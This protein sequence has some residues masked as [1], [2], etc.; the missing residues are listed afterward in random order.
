MVYDDLEV[1]N[2]M[3]AL[4]GGAI[5]QE[6]RLYLTIFYLAGGSYL[7]IQLYVGVSR[8]SFNSILWLE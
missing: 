4:R 6:R 5:T 3:A 2:A 1:A 8:G 7:A